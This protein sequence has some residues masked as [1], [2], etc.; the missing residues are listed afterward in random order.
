M[1]GIRAEEVLLCLKFLEQGGFASNPDIVGVGEA[2]PAVLHAAALERKRLGS[3]MVIGAKPARWSDIVTEKQPPVNQM[4]N[5]VHGALRAYDLPTL[6]R[7][8]TE[9]R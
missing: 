7:L 4:L 5:I 1:V 2:V 9:K 3:V 6:A 8:I